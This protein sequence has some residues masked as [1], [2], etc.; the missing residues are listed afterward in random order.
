MEID[1]G[2]DVRNLELPQRTDRLH[3]DWCQSSKSTRR[4]LVTMKLRPLR[5]SDVQEGCQWYPR[6]P[7]QLVHTALILRAALQH[8]DRAPTLVI[9][10]RRL[11]FFHLNL[12]KCGPTAHR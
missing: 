7:G 8:H 4:R 1:N 11:Y 2:V 9:G 12:A 10:F 5:E 3:P 6:I